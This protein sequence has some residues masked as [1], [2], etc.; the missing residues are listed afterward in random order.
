MSTQKGFLRVK[1]NVYEESSAYPIICTK[2]WHECHQCV[3]LGF[4][5]L[6]PTWNPMLSI[7]ELVSLY[8]S[9]MRPA[10]LHTFSFFPKPLHPAGLTGMVRRVRIQR[11]PDQRLSVRLVIRGCSDDNIACAL[12]SIQ[13]MTLPL[14]LLMSVTWVEISH[15]INFI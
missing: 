8:F 7:S 15:V 12:P 4:R 3:I 14:T 6:W 13:F 11:K 5:D 10:N 1:W 2:D 9:S